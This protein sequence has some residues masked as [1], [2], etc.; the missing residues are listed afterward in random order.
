VLLLGEIAL[1]LVL[2][3]D[4]TRI[5]I[6]SLL[7]SNRLPLRLLMI[8]MPLTIVAGAV[9]A[10]LMFSQLTIWETA[11][12]A[13]ILASTDAGLGQ[14]VVSSRLVPVRI[15]Q[16]LNVEAGLNDGLSVPFLMLFIAL[17]RVTNLLQDQSWLVFTLQQ[18]GFG[19]L[20]GIVLGT[21]GGWLLG[22]TRQRGL[23]A[24]PGIRWYAAQ[25]AKMGAGS[26]ERMEVVEMPTRA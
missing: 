7:K 26:P 9:G 13:T 4:A 3:S 10:A 14:A 8:G 16:A 6:T 24:N 22:R 20:V 18:I 15:R 19:V 23:S 11:I 12:L 1:A 21:G 17:A 25:V 2:F 5:S